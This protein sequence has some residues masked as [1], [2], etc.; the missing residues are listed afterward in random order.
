MVLPMSTGAEAAERG[1]KIARKW[2]YKVKG[3]PESQALV[4]S[5]EN[6]FHGR[7]AC[8]FCF[9]IMFWQTGMMPAL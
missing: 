5:A 7:T 9:S 3:I 6:N 2:D 8:P 4:L 1:I